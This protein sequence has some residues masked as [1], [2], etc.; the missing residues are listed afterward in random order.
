M[1]SL[2]QI[3]LDPPGLDPGKKVSRTIFIISYGISLKIYLLRQ[4]K[5]KTT[6]TPKSKQMRQ[7]QNL[8]VTQET[9]HKT[10]RHPIE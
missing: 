2:L 7:I 8:F 4:K 6:T 1:P 5:T 3:T 10:K 9:T